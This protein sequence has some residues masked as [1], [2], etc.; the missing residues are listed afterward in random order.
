M[1]FNQGTRLLCIMMNHCGCWAQEQKQSSAVWIWVRM[2][3]RSQASLSG[4]RTWCCCKLQHKSQMWLG[5]GVAGAVVEASGAAL[6]Q[7]LA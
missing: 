5:C 3:V 2:W 7:A 4:L 1:A 6:I